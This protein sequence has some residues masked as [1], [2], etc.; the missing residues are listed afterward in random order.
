MDMTGQ[1]GI[2]SGGNMA[3]G[4]TIELQGTG[5]AILHPITS[6]KCPPKGVH[7]FRNQFITVRDNSNAK[8]MVTTL[9][10]AA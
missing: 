2:V 8:G 6:L 7:N 3:G 5:T 1:G 9:G 4:F 10:Q